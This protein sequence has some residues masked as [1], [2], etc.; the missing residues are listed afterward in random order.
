MSE[1]YEEKL[2]KC[3]DQV[4]KVT[5]EKKRH[6]LQLVPCNVA[7]KGLKHDLQKK[8]TIQDVEV[9]TEEDSSASNVL[10]KKK[11]KSL[12]SDLKK[13][14]ETHIV[15]FNGL[16]E[17]KNKVKA[18]TDLSEEVRKCKSDLDEKRKTI[19][20]LQI[21]LNKDKETV[22]IKKRILM[23][24]VEKSGSWKIKISC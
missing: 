16:Q 17:A 18:E 2:E 14:K 1:K 9:D 19:R 4:E 15:L 7:I 13:A 3:R 6:N 23:I 22:F 8:N 24:K 10:K 5:R 11:T 12:S 21:D 20:K